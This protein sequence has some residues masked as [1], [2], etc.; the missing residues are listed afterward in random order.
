[1]VTHPDLLVRPATVMALGMNFLIL[2]IF[3]LAAGDKE[4]KIYRGG[5]DTNVSYEG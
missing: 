1:M 4:L 3:S 2:V 5:M